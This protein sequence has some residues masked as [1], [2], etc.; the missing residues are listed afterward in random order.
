MCLALLPLHP[1]QHLARASVAQ[2]SVAV[3][4]DV[5]VSAARLQ[6]C[7]LSL[8]ALAHDLLRPGPQRLDILGAPTWGM[9]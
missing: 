9:D 8:T 5:P 1:A 7:F 4:E 3:T 6:V 2:H